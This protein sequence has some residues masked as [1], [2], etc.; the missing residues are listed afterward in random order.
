MT[1]RLA[2]GDGVSYGHTWVADAPVTVGLRA[3]S[4][5]PTACR[6][7]PATPPTSASPAYADRCADGSAWTS[8]SS[9]WPARARSRPSAAGDRV[10]LFGSAPDPT[11]QDWAEACGTISY[12]IVSRIGGRFARRWIDSER[13]S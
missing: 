7:T 12:E 8:W 4:G 2:P 1:K 13:D 5:T 11:A 6:A 3:R 9:R 10:V